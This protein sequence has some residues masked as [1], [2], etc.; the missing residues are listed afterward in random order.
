MYTLEFQ[1]CIVL[2]DR[3]E[4]LKIIFELPRTL[5]DRVTVCNIANSKSGQKVIGIMYV[6]T[7]D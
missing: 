6:S 1:A 4:I 2:A 3:Y 7:C 5:T